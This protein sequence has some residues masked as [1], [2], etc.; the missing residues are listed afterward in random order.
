MCMCRTLLANA[1]VRKR[2]ANADVLH[3]ENRI[4]TRTIL[5][6]DEGTCHIGSEAKEVE[7]YE[8]FLLPAFDCVVTCGHATYSE[9]SVMHSWKVQLVDQT[10]LSAGPTA[11]TK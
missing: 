7:L 4:G 2:G 6:V 8:R 3:N 1:S 10:T 5:F 9:I 11:T